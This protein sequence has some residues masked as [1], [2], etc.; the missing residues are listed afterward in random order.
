M[1][2][3]R[4]K[5]GQR[6]NK[7]GKRRKEK[8]ERTGKSDYDYPQTSVWGA[9]HLSGAFKFRHPV[10][11]PGELLFAGQVGIVEDKGIFGLPQGTDLAG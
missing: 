8:G 9:H 6:Y 10:K 1:P 11:H 2:Y 4:R 3:E 5:T 7:K